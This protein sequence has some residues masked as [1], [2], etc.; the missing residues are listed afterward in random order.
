[1][2]YSYLNFTVLRRLWLAIILTANLP[3][4]LSWNRMLE[5]PKFPSKVEG[6]HR[7]SQAVSIPLQQWESTMAGN[8]STR[9]WKTRHG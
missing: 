6:P 5:R 3:K 4:L 7:V 8:R 1:M 9:R 2:A